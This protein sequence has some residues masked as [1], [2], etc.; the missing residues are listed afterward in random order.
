M[1][2]TQ[3]EVGRLALALVYCLFSFRVHANS[4]LEDPAPALP[5][6]PPDASPEMAK[7]WENLDQAL[8]RL[9]KEYPGSFPARLKLAEIKLRDAFALRGLVIGGTPVKAAEARWQVAIVLR[10]YPA[11]EQFCGGS[12]L[13]ERW[14]LTAA[15][16]VDDTSAQQLSIYAGSFDLHKGGSLVPVGRIETH[17]NWR[18]RTFANDIALLELVD[19]L[20]LVAGKAESID[21]AA[22]LP[23]PG[24]LVHASGWGRT[25]PRGARTHILRSVAVPIVDR[26]LCNSNQYYRGKVL[27]GMFCAGIGEKDTCKGDSGGPVVDSLVSAQ[28]AQVGIVSWGF[29]C[30]E[31]NRPG[32]YTDV[33]TYIDWILQVIT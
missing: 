22:S 16:C 33:S 31:L 9:G 15:H 7:R 6:L 21:L 2:I 12:I 13:S 11:S 5:N 29:G 1:S 10:G 8:P 27:A 3:R 32:V 4:I 14:I 23:N 18:R 25:S 19:P 30:G 26:R 20:S 24:M 28:R 17:P